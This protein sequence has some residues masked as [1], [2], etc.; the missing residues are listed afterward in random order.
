[1]KLSLAKDD[2]KVASVTVSGQV[3]QRE[4]NPIQ[5]PLGDLLGPAAYSRQVQLDLSGTNYIDTSGVG[6][7]LTC[8]KRMKQAGGKLT[9]H[10]PHP[11]VINVLM[12]LQLDKVFDIEPAGGPRP[13]AGSKPAAGGE[14]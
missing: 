13:A 6:W 9:L 11:I 12:V 1:M 2:G 3:T 10:H 5:E 4:L 14:A 8:H 7:L